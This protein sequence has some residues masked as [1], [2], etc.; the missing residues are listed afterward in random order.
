MSPTSPEDANTPSFQNV[1]LSSF[2]EYR[3]MEKAQNNSNFDCS[4][5][6]TTLKN[7]TNLISLQSK[8][9]YNTL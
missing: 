4:N 9:G 5:S 6:N 1:V 2:S 8:L 3:A 7:K